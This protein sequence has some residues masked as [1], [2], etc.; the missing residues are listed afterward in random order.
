M[1]TNLV[2]MPMPVAL[3]L[4]GAQEA[5][6]ATS[7]GGKVVAFLRATPSQAWRASEIADALGIELH[8]LSA[9]LRR[10]LARG[11][12]DKQGAYWFVPSERDGARL[13]A[14]HAI[15]QDLNQRLGVEDPADWPQ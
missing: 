14:V 7:N 12:A 13:A 6:N 4:K 10:L 8:T 11:L 15:T 3:L 1:T 9:V 5:E 2:T